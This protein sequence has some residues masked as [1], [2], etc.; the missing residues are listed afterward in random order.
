MMQSLAV[1]PSAFALQGL[2]SG[3][4]GQAATCVLA[5]LLQSALQGQTPTSVLCSRAVACLSATT[6][7]CLA[8]AAHDVIVTPRVIPLSS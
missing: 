7:L 5:L 2:L 6:L 3:T 1:L 8:A 4:Q